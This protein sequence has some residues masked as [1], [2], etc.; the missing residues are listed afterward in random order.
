MLYL[1][2]NNHFCLQDMSNGAAYGHDMVDSSRAIHAGLS[3]STGALDTSTPVADVSTMTDTGG[4]AVETTR[5]GAFEAHTIST[6]S[7]V[8]NGP[9]RIGATLNKSEGNLAGLGADRAY[10]RA[11][12]GPT[13]FHMGEVSA[14]NFDTLPP[15]HGGSTSQQYQTDSS[16]F[17]QTR[18]THRILSDSTLDDDVLITG[19]YIDAP[20]DNVYQGEINLGGLPIPSPPPYASMRQDEEIT[21]PRVELVTHIN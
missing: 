8:Y 2:S 15:F 20:G 7:K 12:S 6:S 3:A 21:V 13:G 4:V 19:D 9:Y 18:Q 14:T 17:S 1:Q 5:F 10:S 16:S 11:S